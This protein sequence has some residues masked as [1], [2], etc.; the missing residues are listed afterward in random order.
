MPSKVFPKT[1]Q[2][3]LDVEARYVTP[4]ASRGAVERPPKE[5]AAI[6]EKATLEDQIQKLETMDDGNDEH[7]QHSLKAKKARLKTL[8]VPQANQHLAGM[9]GLLQRRSELQD[10]FAREETRITEGKAGYQKT[11]NETEANCKARET[12]MKEDLDVALK[13]M[14]EQDE[15]QVK[16]AKAKLTEFEDQHTNLTLEY[17]HAVAENQ[18]GID[19]AQ[20]LLGTQSNK[21]LTPP[22]PAPPGSTP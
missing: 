12:K 18:V 4:D 10:K 9:S 3:C 21:H 13:L 20:A 16:Q 8:S 1:K 15:I 11:V 22:P 7:I 17:N 14:R 2:A 6:D 5:K 19:N